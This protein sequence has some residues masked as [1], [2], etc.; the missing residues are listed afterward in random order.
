MTFSGI[1]QAPY[2]DE[3]KQIS[4]TG[5]VTLSVGPFS[6]GVGSISALAASDLPG[7]FGEENISI[8][9]FGETITGD[10]TFGGFP[11]F[12][13]SGQLPDFGPGIL[14]TQYLF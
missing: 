8:F 10:T 9:G 4:F 3:G 7:S 2:A 14:G 12:T 11:E 6:V 1:Q 5:A 13:V